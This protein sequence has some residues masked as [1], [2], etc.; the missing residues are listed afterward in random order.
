METEFVKGKMYHV[1]YVF[2][3]LT[4]GKMLLGI[5]FVNHASVIRL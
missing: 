3:I 1:S 5:S 4:S 2:W